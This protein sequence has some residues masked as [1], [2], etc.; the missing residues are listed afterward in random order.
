VLPFQQSSVLMVHSVLKSFSTWLPAMLSLVAHGALAARLAGGHAAVS[1]EAP[2]LLQVASPALEFEIDVSAEVE[3]M[4]LPSKQERH[5]AVP[6]SNTHTH[7]YPVPASHSQSPHDPS[8]LH[9]APPSVSAPPV[10]AHSEADSSQPAQ[11]VASEDVPLRFTLAAQS[12][13]EGKGGVTVAQGAGELNG[14]VETFSETGVSVPARLRSASPVSY[15]AGARAEGLEIDV[16]VLLLLDERGSVVEVS[17][18]KHAGFGFDEAALAAVKRYTFSPA[19]KDG[20]AVRVRM[21][22]N[23]QFRLN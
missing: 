5:A 22:W 21:R 10:L 4:N 20:K 18:V 23:V 19:Q 1:I 3:R 16:P 8:L 7:A 9:V 2:S 6:P 13:H 15:P 14:T 11:S 12:A 17:V